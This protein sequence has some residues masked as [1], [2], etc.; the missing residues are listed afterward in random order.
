MAFERGEGYGDKLGN[1]HEGRWVV[2]QM[3]RLLNEELK[4]I[5]IEAIGDDETGVD[6]IVECLDGKRQ[7]H[8]CKAR[9]KSKEYWST[10]DLAAKGILGNAAFQ[11]SRSDVNEFVF[12]SGVPAS[13]LGDICE[14]ARQSKGEAEDFYKCQIEEVGRSRLEPFR[15]FCGALDLCVNTVADRTKAYG[16]LQRFYIYLWPDDR[17]SLEGLTD[18]ASVLVTGEP[19]V[20][21]ACLRDYAESNLRRSIT[22][23]DLSVHL[24]TLGFQPR[25]FLNDS[26]IVPAM[27][28]LQLRFEESINPGLI[29]GK[30]IDRKETEELVKAVKKGGLVVIHGVSGC[31]K[32]GVLFD[33]S[34]RLHVEGQPYFPIRLDRQEPRNTS[35]EFGQTLGLPDSPAICMRSLTGDKIP[36]ILLD[37]LDA[38]RWTSS[39]SQNSL[40]VCKEIVREAQCVSSLGRKISVVLSCRTFDLENDP[41]IKKWIE[42]QNQKERQICIVRI[43]GLSDEQIGSVVECYG[44]RFDEFSERQ[45]QILRIPQH[46][47]MWVTIVKDG[48]VSRFQ[49]AT[50]L[51][52]EFWRNRY[53]ELVKEG[54]TETEVDTVLNLLVDYM[55]RKQ[56]ICAPARL[57]DRKQ[58]MATLLQT[59]GI[60]QA[61]NRQI[62]FC[63]QSY[64]DYR[65]AARLLAEI[66]G[67]SG[68]VVKWL[69]T[70]EKQSL[71]RREQFRQVLLM[72][73]DESPDEFFLNIK[74]LLENTSIRFHLKHLALEVIAQIKKPTDTLCNYLRELIDDDYWRDHVRET[75]YWGHPQYVQSL[76]NAGVIP[77]SLDF[78][79]DE[80]RD[81]MLGLLQSVCRATPDMVYDI[82]SPN[83][84]KGEEWPKRILNVLPWN[85][86]DDSDS[87]FGLR[88]KL[89]RKGEMCSFVQWGELGEK[90]PVRAIKLIEAVVSNWDSSRFQKNSRAR[91]GHQSRLEEWTTKDLEALKTVAN[92]Y[93]NV[94]WD[95][96]IPHVERLTTSDGCKDF[97]DSLSDWLPGGVHELESKRRSISR[98]II[99]MLCEAGRT[100]ALSN[101]DTLLE[102]TRQYENSVSVVIQEIIASSYVALPPGDSDK[103]IEWL[104]EKYQWFKQ[105]CGDP[106]E[107]PVY[108][109]INVHSCHCSNALF[110]TLEDS[111]HSYHSPNELKDAKWCFE[112]NR[113]YGCSGDYWG[114]HQYFYLPAL[115]VERANK[116]TK[117][118]I[119]VLARKFEG[120]GENRLFG[121]SLHVGGIVT[122]PLP[123]KKTHMLSDSNWLQIVNNNEIPEH[124]T[125][126]MTQVS[127]DCVAESAVIHF[128]N[129]MGTA[130]KR[131]PDRFGQLALRFPSDVNQRYVWAVIGGMALVKPCDGLSDDER[132]SWQPA[133]IDTME[134]FLAHHSESDDREVALSFCRL[135]QSRSEEDWSDRVI[136]RLLNYANNHPDLETGKL[137][138][139]CNKTSSEASVSDL[140]TNS[141]NCVRGVAVE[142]I[143]Q[144]LWANT[145][146]LER[147]KP[148]LEKAAKDAHPA[149]RIA[150]VQA[151]LPLLN[152]KEDYAVELFLQACDTDLRVAACPRSEYYFNCIR[153]DPPISIF[154]KWLQRLRIFVLGQ[155]SHKV[156]SRYTYA[157]KLISLVVSM[158][159]S[160]LVDVS[161]KGAT[162]VCARWLFHGLFADELKRG[163]DGTVSQRKGIAHLVS[164]LIWKEE[165]TQECM[166]ILSTLFNDGE[167]EVRCKASHTFYNRTESL[168]L[169]GVMPFI[170]GYIKSEAFHDD[171]TGLL[172]TFEKYTGSLIPFA[173][174]IYVIC[175]EFVGPLAE[176][177]RNGATG[178]A[179]DAS[180][181]P[182]LLLRLYEQSEGSHPDI[183]DKCLDAF[184]ALFEHR[185]GPARTLTKSI[186][187]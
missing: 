157:G 91:R 96:L 153:R 141:H 7:F 114:K 169:P 118:L 172:L 28:N 89:A 92:E 13:I 77:G 168:E 23:I 71:F 133:S 175:Q 32:S 45:K 102:K 78:D 135:I 11:L 49:S 68:S 20:V 184:D 66:D 27:D 33:L 163:L 69:G 112:I 173:E 82:L 30:L 187:C 84:D 72:L 43:A 130:A 54:V 113:K 10:A 120:Y 3:L 17:N 65:I 104:I 56:K 127:Q 24:T 158:F 154:R 88:L 97:D 50:E 122:S 109:L 161:E 4:S 75:V 12:V 147:F 131:L 165:C 124:G 42:E 115:A 44:C 64:L 183:R 80:K 59:L 160:E 121:R 137:N 140:Y 116:K 58:E 179:H 156:T 100:L 31:G 73:S 174:T 149:V 41:E 99:A 9:N 182:S 185:I 26:R 19:Q 146:W 70:K 53:Q 166:Q 18:R 60:V 142:A 57:L 36:V 134:R 186:T 107:S 129:A 94:A 180:E 110:K 16:Y 87:T 119:A 38:L 76:I 90:C 171:P 83:V 103:A 148:T 48:V 159:D 167:S 34:K 144:M 150:L 95:L 40:G 177:S 170:Q 136:E 145:D 62:T 81:A 86:E 101:S 61:D 35:R 151:V 79:S 176:L 67:G 125:H 55:E 106:K 93:A 14:S 46:L 8:Q 138:V 108:H 29:N 74:E 21:I 117:E 2:K 128:A 22:A 139:S 39:H 98:G 15:R 162:E 132:A 25:R 155:R 164:E 105:E 47:A 181:I 152:T 85:C 143:G 178:I 51:M 37:Q 63:H 126:K 5:T 123:P 6:L 1:R 111:I 52:R